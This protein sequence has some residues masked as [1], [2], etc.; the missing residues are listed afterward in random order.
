MSNENKSSEIRVSNWTLAT[1]TRRESVTCIR[2]LTTLLR[3]LRRWRAG[4]GLR[5]CRSTRGHQ[6]AVRWTSSI[7]YE[8]RSASQRSE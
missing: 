3:A 7:S 2:T 4:R 6:E 8:A 1:G 5:R